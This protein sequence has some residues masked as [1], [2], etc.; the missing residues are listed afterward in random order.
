MAPIGICPDLRW[1]MDY[2]PLTYHLSAV[3]ALTI[4]SRL[5]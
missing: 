3:D 4:N 2:N 5:L 1:L